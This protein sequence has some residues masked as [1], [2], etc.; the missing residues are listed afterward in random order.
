MISGVRHT[1]RN[2]LIAGILVLMPAVITYFVL[3]FL[4]GLMADLI[5]PALDVVNSVLR[6]RGMSLPRSLY[7]LLGFGLLSLGVF[8]VGTLTRNYVGRRVVAVGESMVHRIPIAGTVYSA[9]KQ[10][11]HAFAAAEKAA[12]RRIVL[13]EY[14][15][16]GLFSIAFV[17]ADFSGP[18][19]AGGETFLTCFVPTTPNPTSGLMIVVPEKDCLKTDMTVEEAMR[20]VISAGI[21]V[22][23]RWA[24][25]APSLVAPTPSGD[26]EATPPPPFGTVGDA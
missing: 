18:G 26:V 7:P 21:I 15:R 5:Y 6:S 17:T 13:V 1:V 22:P 14:P 19:E 24:L 3:A 12:F 16:K 11:L 23:A 8:L 4:Y 10:T 9:A 20:F 25:Q 2:A